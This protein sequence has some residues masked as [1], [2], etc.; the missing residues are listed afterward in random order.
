M[1]LKKYGLMMSTAAIVLTLAACTETKEE[2]KTE[3]KGEVSSKSND[4]KDGV[5]IKISD[6]K[7]ET[8]VIDDTK[9]S[10]YDFKVLNE[11]DLSWFTKID[12]VISFEEKRGNTISKDQAIEVDT[13]VKDI[14]EKLLSVGGFEFLGFKNVTV[15]YTFTSNLPFYE[16]LNTKDPSEG[17]KVSYVKTEQ[18]VLSRIVYTV[19]SVTFDDLV[20]KYT[21]Q[22]GSATYTDS[23]V[24]TFANE[25]TT[26]SIVAVGED[27]S[28][29]YAPTDYT[30]REVAGKLPEKTETI[31]SEKEE[32]DK[33]KESTTE[34][35]NTNKEEPVK[36]E[37]SSEK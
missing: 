6:E 32:S 13:S 17:L 37:K 8:I 18:D 35:P 21:K 20:A 11:S 3:K 30:V 1:K 2:D 28:I 15:N 14:K 4:I 29:I 12:N 7:G 31:S 23:E 34:K 16:P 5:S 36:E 9:L 33:E 19:P 24:V 22:Y 27:V 26:I 25:S 10:T